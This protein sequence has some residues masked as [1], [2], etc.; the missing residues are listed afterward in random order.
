MYVHDLNLAAIGLPYGDLWLMLNYLPYAWQTSMPGCGGGGRYFFVRSYR[1]EN[2]KPVAYD[3]FWIETCLKDREKLAE[4]Q[5]R[6]CIRESNGFRWADPQMPL[7]RP[8]GPAHEAERMPCACRSS[9]YVVGDVP[10]TPDHQ[11]KMYR[12]SLYTLCV[13]CPKLTLLAERFDAKYIKLH[14]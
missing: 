3:P 10:L 11:T 2:G 13:V 12:Q 5:A 7:A 1:I 4:L 8:F 6:T 9:G 14:P